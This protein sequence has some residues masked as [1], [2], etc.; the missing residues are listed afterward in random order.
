MGSFSYTISC[1]C[2]RPLPV[3]LGRRTP[4]PSGASSVLLVR[5]CGATPAEE[6]DHAGVAARLLALPQDAINE[7]EP[8][9]NS[10]MDLSLPARVMLAHTRS[11]QAQ[12]TGQ[13]RGRQPQQPQEGR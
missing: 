8:S 10:F 11:L 12:V 4:V 9:L 1:S 7:A 6:E 3:T 2:T 5:A 13:S